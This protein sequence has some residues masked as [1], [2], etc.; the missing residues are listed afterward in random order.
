MNFSLP[1]LELR[2]LVRPVLA[3]DEEYLLDTVK[4]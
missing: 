2:P 4:V 3:A 1:F